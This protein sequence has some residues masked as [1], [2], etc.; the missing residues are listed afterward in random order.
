MRNIKVAAAQLGPIQKADSRQVV[1]ARMLSAVKVVSAGDTTLVPDTVVGPWAV[2][3]AEQRLQGQ[4]RIIAAGASAFRF[5]ELVPQAVFDKASASLLAP[6]PRS[7]SML[8]VS[9][10]ARVTLSLPCRR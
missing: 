3:A 2:R 5:G 9:A 1:V 7:T 4:V 6:A 8:A 10:E